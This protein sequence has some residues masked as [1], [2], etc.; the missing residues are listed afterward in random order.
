M[1]S[2]LQEIKLGE[3]KLGQ[4]GDAFYEALMQAHEGLSEQES[5]ALNMRLVLILANQ[6]GEIDVLKRIIKEASDI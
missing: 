5:H 4:D 1:V 3:D 2:K 6:V